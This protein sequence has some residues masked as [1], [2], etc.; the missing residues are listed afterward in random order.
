MDTNITIMIG[1]LTAEPSIKYLPSSSCCLE[2]QIA[3]NGIKKE[4]VSYFSCVMFG[5]PAEKI[6]NY[7]KKGSQIAIVGYLKQERWTDKQTQKQVSKVRIVANSIQLLGSKK[8][9]ENPF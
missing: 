1:R 9:E 4:D 3:N 2:F 5:E 7:L 6:S 8:E